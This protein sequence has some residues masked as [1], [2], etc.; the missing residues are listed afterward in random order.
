[1][2]KTNPNKSKLIMFSG[3][4]GVGKSTLSYRLARETGIAILT[5]DQIERTLLTSNLASETGRLAYDLLIET[6]EFNMQ[7]GASLILDA[8]FGTNNLRDLFI[9]QAAANNAAFYG[10]DCICSDKGLWQ[11]RLATRPEMVPGWQPAAWT[12][13][14]RVQNYYEEWAYPHLTLDAVDSFESNYK[15]LLAYLAQ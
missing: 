8:V 2:P 13:S 5:K 7:R 14:L 10:I 4:P 9:R 15:K 1:M 11:S 12:D 6:A 3:P